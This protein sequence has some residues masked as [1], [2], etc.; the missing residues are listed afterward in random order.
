M[1]A[2]GGRPSPL[3]EVRPQEMVLRRTVEQN[4]DAV[5]F[6]TLDVPMPQKVDQPLALLLSA[7]FPDPE[8]V[9][10]VPKISLPARPSRRFPSSWCASWRTTWGAITSSGYSWLSGLGWCVALPGLPSYP[11]VQKLSTVWTQHG[12][13]YTWTLLEE[14]P[15]RAVRTWSLG[16]SVLV[17][18]SG[19][20]CRCVWILSVAYDWTFQE[21]LGRNALLDSGY[22]FCVSLQRLC[23]ECGGLVSCSVVSVLTQNGEVCSADAS[24]SGLFRAAHTWKSGHYFDDD[25]W[26]RVGVT[27]MGIFAAFLSPR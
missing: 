13:V 26:L 7:H 8:Q 3:V 16:Y 10:D 27:V 18:V 15:A 9:I 25:P 12:V 14:F 24:V 2:A 20:H 11:V 6:P 19:C 5:T 21:M 1:L 17:L 22:M 4:I 23:D